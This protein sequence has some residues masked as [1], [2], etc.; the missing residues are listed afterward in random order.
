MA[1]AGVLDAAPV[2]VPSV[3]CACGRAC[4][5]GE[6]LTMSCF[7][8]PVVPNARD[9]WDRPDEVAE[10]V[11]AHGPDD[12]LLE[13]LLAAARSGG[14]SLRGRVDALTAL[15]SARAMLD[16]VQLRLIADMGTSDP[17]GRDWAREDVAAALHVS[18]MTAANRLELAR[19]A[20]TRFPLAMKALDDGAITVMHVRRLVEGCARLDEVEAG[21]VEQLALSQAGAQTVGQF[22]KTVDQFAMMLDDASSQKRHELARKDRRVAVRA[23]ADGMA[24]FT[25]YAPLEQVAMAKVVVDA[26]AARIHR[27]DPRT[28]DQRRADV[29][30][31]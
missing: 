17:D 26:L 1:P 30:T 31:R 10:W 23:L 13:P 19:A 3:V 8:G 12:A 22:G 24:E 11:R 29:S 7:T 20:V 27:G 5:P 6:C 18:P 16:A 14:L 15:E 4:D 25:A 2:D 28:A 21:W 9:A